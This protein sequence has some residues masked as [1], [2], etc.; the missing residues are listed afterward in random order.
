MTQGRD[1]EA[2]EEL[3]YSYNP[4]SVIEEHSTYV[5]SAGELA[6]TVI[7]PHQ[8]REKSSDTDVP[9]NLCTMRGAAS[10]DNLADGL[11]SDF[12]YSDNAQEG[13]ENP[14]LNVLGEGEEMSSSEQGSTAEE[15]FN[16]SPY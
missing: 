15:G 12:G 11:I 2:I 16:V 9:K 4:D 8:V 13:V 7:I 5:P 1:L 14:I 10:L 6:S 3:D